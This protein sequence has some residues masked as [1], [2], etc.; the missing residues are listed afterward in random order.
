MHVVKSPAYA[1]HFVVEEVMLA[2]SRFVHICK[3]AVSHKVHLDCERHR[4]V[5]DRFNVYNRLWGDW[6]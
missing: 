5:F 2:D 3:E 6:R 1:G 4:L